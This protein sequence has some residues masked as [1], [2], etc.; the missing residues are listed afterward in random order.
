MRHTGPNQ[1]VRD[2]VLD[3]DGHAC[4]VCGT[5]QLLQLHHRRARSMGGTRR[6]DANLCANLITLCLTCHATVESRREWAIGQGLLVG[7][8]ETPSTVPVW[9]GHAWMLLADDGSS[10]LVAAA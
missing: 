8:H 9:Y 5:S 1:A 10:S 4:I 6:A 2:D 7:Q 3:R